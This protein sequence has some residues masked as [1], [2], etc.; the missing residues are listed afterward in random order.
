MQ[1]EVFNNNDKITKI[2]M[3]E[4]WKNSVNAKKK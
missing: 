3:K 4:I 2:G 1:G